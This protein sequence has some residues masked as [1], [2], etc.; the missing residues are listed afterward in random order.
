MIEKL[1]NGLEKIRTNNVITDTF[2]LFVSKRDKQTM[3]E[4]MPP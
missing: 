2:V 4:S 1:R 3:R